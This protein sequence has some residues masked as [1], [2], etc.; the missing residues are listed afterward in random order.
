MA[1]KVYDI[2]D[3]NHR[4]TVAR[5]KGYPKAVDCTIYSIDRDGKITHTTQ[6]LPVSA[7]ILNVD[8]NPRATDLETATLNKLR[9]RW[10]PALLGTVAVRESG[11]TLND[12]VAN[13]LFEGL[14]EQKAVTF[15]HKFLAMLGQHNPDAMAIMAILN[16]HNLDLERK[17]SA[18]GA[19]RSPQTLWRIYGGDKETK[20]PETLETTLATIIHAWGARHE[21]LDHL[22]LDG[23]AR[24][25]RRYGDDINKESLATK[26]AK[27]PGGPSALIGAGRGLRE[28]I[29]GS[30]ANCVAEVIVETYNRGLRTRK[31]AGWRS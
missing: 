25:L 26:L 6:S 21:A 16:K 2:I 23:I 27:Y 15:Y 29:G 8:V 31:L 14:N 5:E 3:G 4:I 9:N 30:A 13:W 12:R 18:D 11:G 7:L 28:L 24:V 19:I 10:D 17:G 20:D 1:K 22:I